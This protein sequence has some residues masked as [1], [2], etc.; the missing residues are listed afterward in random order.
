MVLAFLYSRV[1]EGDGPALD[2]QLCQLPP[3]LR[4]L[5]GR[6]IFDLGDE[7][8]VLG[9]G[10]EGEALAQHFTL[11]DLFLVVRVHL[12]RIKDKLLG[13]LRLVKVM[14]CTSSV[15]AARLLLSTV[16]GEV[17]VDTDKNILGQVGVLRQR[18]GFVE[19]F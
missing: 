6:I 1:V 7:A 17:G 18:V 15:V 12:L 13:L 2:F 16:V 3:L 10:L 4:R 9:G 14:L 19:Y 11:D 8:E 5:L